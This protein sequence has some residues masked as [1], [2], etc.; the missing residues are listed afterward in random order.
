M[1]EALT[2]TKETNMI[3]AAAKQRIQKVSIKVILKIAAIH[4][5]A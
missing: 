4:L 1:G 2:C 5:D 3:M